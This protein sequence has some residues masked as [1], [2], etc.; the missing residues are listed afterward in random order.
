LAAHGLLMQGLVDDAGRWRN[1]GVGIYRE[2][3]LLHMAPPPSQ[4]QHLIADLLAWLKQNTV[5]LWSPVACFI[6]NSIHPSIHSA[7]AMAAWDA[8]G[9]P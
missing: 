3:Q 4:V 8:Y 9:K 5:P 6:T 1:S 2:Q 7:M